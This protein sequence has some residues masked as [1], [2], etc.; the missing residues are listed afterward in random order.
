MSDMSV[1]AVSSSKSNG[2]STSD[3]YYQMEMQDAQKNSMLS[4]EQQTAQEN[5]RMLDQSTGYNAGNSSIS[6]F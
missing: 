1:G 3:L 5:Q 6:S 4:D 2:T